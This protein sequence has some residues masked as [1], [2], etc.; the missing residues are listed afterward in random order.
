MPFA[1]EC[2]LLLVEVIKEGGNTREGWLLL[3]FDFNGELNLDLADTTKVSNAM[4]CSN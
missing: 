3:I 2:P 4:Q 1:Y